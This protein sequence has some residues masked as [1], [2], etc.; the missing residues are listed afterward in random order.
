MLMAMS[1]KELFPDGYE[2]D[3]G[4]WEISPKQLHEKISEVKLIDVRQPEEYTG[5]LGHIANSTLSTLQTELEDYLDTLPKEQRYV[6]ICRSGK[7]STQAC[8]FAEERGIQNVANLGGG[9]I[10]WNEENLPTESE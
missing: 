1:I 6:F 5:E 7:R 10:A 3:E 8:L 2:N 9:M 4:V